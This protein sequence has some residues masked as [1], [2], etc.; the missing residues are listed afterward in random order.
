[1][2]Q[3]RT[4]KMDEYG[5]IGRF[6]SPLLIPDTASFIRKHFIQEVGSKVTSVYRISPLIF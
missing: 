2:M 1:M 4:K 3:S 6:Y 5:I